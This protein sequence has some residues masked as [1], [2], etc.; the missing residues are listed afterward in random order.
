MEIWKPVEQTPIRFRSEF[1]F[2][3]PNFEPNPNLS[4]KYG[5]DR[6]KFRK[7]CGSVRDIS[8]LF[9]TLSICELEASQAL[10]KHGH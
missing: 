6:V 9:S 4:E 1:E 5:I 10:P 7:R 3:T 8:V 2:T